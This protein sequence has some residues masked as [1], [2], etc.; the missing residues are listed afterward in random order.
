MPSTVGNSEKFNYEEPFDTVSRGSL[1]MSL[2]LLL[3]VAVMVCALI[4]AF[5]YMG[6]L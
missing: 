1:A 4:A 5:A 6:R 3:I 2:Q